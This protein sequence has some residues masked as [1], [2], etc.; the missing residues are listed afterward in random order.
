[1]EKIAVGYQN[2][3]SRTCS[4]FW[5]HFQN[6]DPQVQTAAKDVFARWQSGGNAAGVERVNNDRRK[7]SAD[8][9]HNRFRAVGVWEGSLICWYW[10]G[11]HTEYIKV[12]SAPIPSTAEQCL[13]IW[14]ARIEQ[15]KTDT[16]KP[17]QPQQQQKS[18]YAPPPKEPKAWEQDIK[19]WL[20]NK[21]AG[22]IIIE[23]LGY[24]Y[25][26]WLSDDEKV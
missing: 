9:L 12:I 6:L 2:V 8:I 10:I 23:T 15:I 26:Q 3:I 25:A 17:Q 19:E 22:G 21:K 13:K 18:K 5:T 20:Q 7:V 24:K 11:T 16:E 1:M 14:Q 4:T